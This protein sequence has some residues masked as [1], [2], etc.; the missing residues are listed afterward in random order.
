MKNVVFNFNVMII[1]DTQM[2]VLAKEMGKSFETKALGTLS[3]KYFVDNNSSTNAIS[4]L[5]CSGL[6]TAS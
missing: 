3:N 5:V 4:T 1:L 6:D 2:I